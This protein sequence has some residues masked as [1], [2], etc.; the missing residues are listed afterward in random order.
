LNTFSLVYSQTFIEHGYFDRLSNKHGC[1]RFTEIKTKI[2]RIRRGR[3]CKSVVSASRVR[4]LTDQC[5]IEACDELFR[6]ENE[7]QNLN[8]KLNTAQ[9]IP[10]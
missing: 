9:P 5:S 7:P 6:L 8:V 4:L 1:C 2:P 10:W 3:Q